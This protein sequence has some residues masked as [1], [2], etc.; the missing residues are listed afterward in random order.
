MPISIGVHKRRQGMPP[1]IDHRIRGTA[2]PSG[3]HG[4]QPYTVTKITRQSRRGTVDHG[5]IT[6][7]LLV[8]A[9]TDAQPWCG[10]TWERSQSSEELSPPES[11]SSAV[12]SGRASPKMRSSRAIS[13]AR[14]CAGRGS[15][16]GPVAEIIRPIRRVHR[17]LCWRAVR[18]SPYRHGP[19]R[20]CQADSR[21][22]CCPTRPRGRATGPRRAIRQPGRTRAAP[23]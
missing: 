6:A 22:G 16:E 13:L 2:R 4:T 11:R 21:R 17:S 10:G 19:P 23:R 3:H 9:V 7:Y 18:E 1:G 15:S 14:R 12:V 8:A 20:G 5:T